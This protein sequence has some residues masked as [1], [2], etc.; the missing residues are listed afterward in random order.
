MKKQ[1]YLLIIFSLII[2]I[3]AIIYFNFY[4]WTTY[5]NI[6]HNYLLKYPSGWTV[7]DQD[8]SVKNRVLITSNK[9][10]PSL[11]ID[12]ALKEARILIDIRDKPDE[13][14]KEWFNKMQTVGEPINVV[15]QED[16]TVDGVLGLKARV[17]ILTDEIVVYL[18]KDNK[19]YEINFSTGD[20]NWQKFESVFN[21]I[22][23]TFRF[24]D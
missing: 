10:F 16:I 23:S 14:L 9:N 5:K 7:I 22:L 21:K 17:K 12:N 24:L 11:S 3:I 6:E 19:L 18:V 1:T 20:K 13:S 4:Y 2:I 8:S 15:Y